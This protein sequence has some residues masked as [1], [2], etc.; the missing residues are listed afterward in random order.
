MAFRVSLL[1]PLIK[2]KTIFNKILTNELFS[3]IHIH[4]WSNAI[5]QCQLPQAS[6]LGQYKS[7]ANLYVASLCVASLCDLFLAFF[8][9]LDK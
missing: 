1:I 5:Q 9:V 2:I 7:S 6:C 4:F 3:N 8:G